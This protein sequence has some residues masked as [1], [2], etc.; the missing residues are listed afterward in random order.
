MQNSIETRG[1]LCTELGAPV[2]QAISNL[3]SGKKSVVERPKR[4][5]V[6]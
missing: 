2:F 6:A 4:G 1:N 3:I 5:Q